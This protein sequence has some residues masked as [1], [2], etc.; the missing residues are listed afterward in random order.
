MM[1]KQL[2]DKAPAPSLTKEEQKALLR[3]KEKIDKIQTDLIHS[4]G[5][6]DEEIKLAVKVGLIDPDQAWWWK[7]EWQ[8]GE[9]EAEREIAQKE[10]S[11][12][13]KSVDR[14]IEHLNKG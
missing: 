6:N 9:R 2:T 11:G 14:L 12:P 7:E 3:V 5:L 4:Q 13:F 8:K 1:P 10:V